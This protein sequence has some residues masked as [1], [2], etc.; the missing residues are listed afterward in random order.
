MTRGRPRKY[1]FADLEIGE[2]FVVPLRS[3]GH[4]TS[5]AAAA[6]YHEHRYG[7]KFTTRVIVFVGDAILTPSHRHAGKTGTHCQVTRVA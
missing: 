7:G 6:N 2:S 4:R 5:I 1:H 3:G